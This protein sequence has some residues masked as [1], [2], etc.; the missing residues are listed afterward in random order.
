MVILLN[1]AGDK[2]GTHEVLIDNLP[3]MPDNIK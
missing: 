2:A 3:G 1:I